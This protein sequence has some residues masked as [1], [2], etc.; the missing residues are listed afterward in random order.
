[1]LVERIDQLSVSMR[2]LSTAM[3]PDNCRSREELAVLTKR[4]LRAKGQ[5]ETLERQLDQIE[6]VRTN[7][8][9]LESKVLVQSATVTAAQRVGS[10][11][12]HAPTRGEVVQSAARV[13]RVAR[14]LEASGDAVS[15]LTDVISDAASTALDENEVEQNEKDRE[16]TERI[17]AQ[18]E[19]AQALR[20]LAQVP[21]DDDGGGRA[22]AGGGGVKEEKEEEEERAD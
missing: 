12:A 13:T 2:A 7:A 3:H 6:A 14:D 18:W 11:G 19:D 10:L 9:V 5:K 15:S 4:F 8:T 21:G 1:M 22:R 17:V 20:H 16:E